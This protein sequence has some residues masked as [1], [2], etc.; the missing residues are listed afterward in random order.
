MLPFFRTRR[1]RL[2]T[3][4]LLA[5]ALAPAA[6]WA[7]EGGPRLPPGAPD[8][9]LGRESLRL[10]EDGRL[11][12]V[13]VVN[14]G[15]LPSGPTNLRVTARPPLI[16]TVD[17]AAIY[18]RHHFLPNERGLVFW[19]EAREREFLLR[20]RWQGDDDSAFFSGQVRLEDAAGGYLRPRLSARFGGIGETDVRLEDDGWVVWEAT[21]GRPESGFDLSLPRESEPAFFTVRGVALCGVANLRQTYIGNWWITRY[22]RDMFHRVGGTVL[23]EDA[24]Q[25]GADER[26]LPDE[27]DVADEEISPGPLAISLADLRLTIP[28]DD[29]RLAHVALPAWSEPGLWLEE[30]VPALDPGEQARVAIPLEGPV[31]DLFVEIDPNNQVVEIREGNN[32]AVRKG[33]GRRAM[34]SLH[35]HASLSEGTASV[36][37]Q[38]DLLTRSGYDAVF[39]T[40]H[41]WRV[42]GHRMPP[43][44]S[45]ESAFSPSTTILVPKRMDRGLR[46][47]FR[48]TAERKT[49]LYKSLRFHVERDAPPDGGARR[50][51]Y[52][53]RA[54]RGRH[55]RPLA[56]GL[57]LSLDLFPDPENPFDSEFTIELELSDQP[58]VKRRLLYRIEAL[59]AAAT[60]AQV[61]L[62]PPPAPEELSRVAIQPGRWTH[63]VI[64]AA[65]HAKAL[66]PEG[67]DNSLAAIQFGVAVYRGSA[68][69]D[70][71]RLGME[72]A[73]TGEPL[74]A[75]Q[76]EWARSYP[77]IASHV[78]TEISYYLPHL[79]PFTA[80]RFLLDYRDVGLQEYIKAAVQETRR[81]HGALSVN[82]PLGFGVP[83]PSQHIEDEI[84]HRF[85]GA[86]LLEVGYRF[87]GGADLTAH[88]AFWDRGL[89]EGIPASG[90]GV[91]DAH[92][93]G[94]GNGFERDENNFATWMDAD[95]ASVDSLIDALL[96]GDLVF[97]D[98]LLFFGNL[99]LTVDGR[100]RPGAVVLSQGQPREVSFSA[101]K[102]PPGSRLDLVVDGQK[103]AASEVGAGGDTTGTFSLSPSHRWVRLES[104]D[105]RGEPVAFTNAILFLPELPVDGLP[106]ARVHAET[107]WGAVS[108]EGRYRI[109]QFDLGPGGLGLRGEGPPGKLIV[110]GAGMEPDSVVVAGT[111]TG[112]AW[113]YDAAADRISIPVSGAGIDLRWPGRG[114]AVPGGWLTVGVVAAL[115][116]LTVLWLVL[117]RRRWS[118]RAG[119]A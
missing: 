78:S 18:P 66:Y 104:W 83:Y 89:A 4:A 65:E 43:T 11:L 25:S 45:F 79:N 14:G 113:S 57:A 69:W 41:D 21:T 24:T 101:E 87:R 67:L 60:P 88:L 46:A 22:F 35:T 92:G 56:Q 30:R 53:L 61:V 71:D 37:T 75:L 93:P 17:G 98:P 48:L 112:V 76:E 84:R 85:F 62:P 38:M 105:A 63:L 116:A 58:H 107:S 15:S 19:P 70:M 118:R 10:S 27:G 44:F 86:D 26:S 99:E 34:V 111:S 96:A 1:R 110:T 77:G 13:T 64:P 40:E 50:V 36:D 54:H 73:V 51:A 95:P 103:V 29:V 82:H 90:I 20:V 108:G 39:W 55:I 59:P 2:L 117:G 94:R 119:T 32:T 9:V 33:P 3:P 49:D 102:L 81:R 47:S 114:P 6:A 106:A 42:A 91:T 16:A 68:D 12:E 72:A 97:G 109:T 74:L 7:D 31:A 8:L 28:L 23:A 5:V 52:A 80:Q 115:L 100:Y